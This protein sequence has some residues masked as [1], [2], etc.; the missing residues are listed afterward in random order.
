MIINDITRMQKKQKLSVSSVQIMTAAI[1]HLCSMNDVILNWKKIRKFIK[2]DV[3]KHKDDEY[4]DDDIRKLLEIS[5][6]RTK[7]IFLVFASTGIRVDALHDIKLRNLTKIDNYNLYKIVA[8]GEFKEEYFTFTTPECTAIIDS[9][10]EYR[11]RSGEILTPNSYLI[12]EVF[13]NN[14][15]KQV[16]EQSR[17]VSTSTIS[18]I[19]QNHLVKAGIRTPFPKDIKNKKGARHPKAQDH[20]FRKHFETRLLNS[21]VN[22]IKMKMLM[23]HDI[24]LEESY[25]RPNEKELL[26]EYLKA[27]NAL[28]INEE[29]RLKEKVTEL[30]QK[31]S[32]IQLLKYQ[33]AMKEKQHEMKEKRYETEIQEVNDKVG[34]IIRK[35]TNTEDDEQ[36]MDDFNPKRLFWGNKAIDK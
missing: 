34:R 5:D 36:P 8:Y 3:P 30:E 28:T 10:L 20:A 11:K 18:K 32:E 27:V 12:R 26:T 15:I 2:T 23:G 33:F 29:N 17:Q 1:Q 22:V 4:S 24:G 31:Q 25:L 19:V 16:K 13:D 9:Y 7:T 21:D 6:L 14:D 35:L